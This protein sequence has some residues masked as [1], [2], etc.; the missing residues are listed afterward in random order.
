MYE[1]PST[2]R[3]RR[4]ALWFDES[5]SSDVSVCHASFRISAP[6][7]DPRWQ[8]CVRHCPWEFSVEGDK[9][10]NFVS[11]HRLSGPVYR[12]E[13]GRLA[14]PCAGRV[15]CDANRGKHGATLS[16]AHDAVP[17]GTAELLAE[18]YLRVHRATRRE[19]Y[20][21]TSGSTLNLG[22]PGTGLSFRHRLGANEAAASPELPPSFPLCQNFPFR[23]LHKP[24]RPSRARPFP[25]IHE[26]GP[27]GAEDLI[28]QASDERS[29]LRGSIPVAREE[30]EAAQ[31]RLRRA[32]N[33]FFGL[34]L[35]N[36]IPERT[37][38]VAEREAEL[39]RQEDRLAGAFIDADFALDAAA[40]AAFDALAMAFEQ[41]ATCS[42]NMGRDHERQRGSRADAVLRIDLG[43]TASPSCSA[44]R[45][46]KCCSLAPRCCASRMR[47]VPTFSSIRHSS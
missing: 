2:S 29:K 10:S 21:V 18:R 13:E 44:L 27:S 6:R 30:L 8:T 40:S 35:K 22:I 33:W 24:E 34:F 15:Q 42:R 9:F 4:I 25:G 16:E 45:K 28:R 43:S 47:T 12:T 23:P 11:Q 17:G 36:K 5:G 31:R 3:S 14:G 19:R 46:T 7:E 20:S 39:K 38:A 32:Q 37:T 41:V 26:Y 1:S